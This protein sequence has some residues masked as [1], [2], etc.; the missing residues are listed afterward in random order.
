MDLSPYV[1][2]LRRELVATAEVGGDEARALRRAAHR[3][4]GGVAPARAAE[5]PL[6]GRRGDHQPAGTRRGVDVRLRGGDLGFVVT[7]PAVT[8]LGPFQG[9]RRPRSGLADEPAPAADGDDAATSRITL[10]LPENLKVRVEDAAGR[11]GF[12]VNTWLVRA[13]SAAW[14]RFAPAGSSG[15][16][17]AGRASRCSG[18]VR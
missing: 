16:G 13:V 8:P 6:H 17:G 7:V 12:S 9:S 3:P 14:S 15:A 2:Q 1:D 10:R 4:A 11:D 5:R 18:W